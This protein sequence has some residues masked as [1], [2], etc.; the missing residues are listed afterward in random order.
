MII[1][2]SI[3]YLRLHRYGTGILEF[4]IPLNTLQVISGTTILP[5]RWPNQQRHSTGMGGIVEFN[6]PLDTLWV[7]SET[8]LRVR[9]PNQQCH[10][11]EER[12]L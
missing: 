12:W 3:E 10:S 2:T 5:V 6:V 1:N 8:V 7:I 9:W 4:N 11:T